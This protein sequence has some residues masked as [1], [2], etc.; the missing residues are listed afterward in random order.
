LTVR[1]ATI[2]MFQQ[3]WFGYG[4]NGLLLW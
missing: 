1:D 4:W 2:I 3:L